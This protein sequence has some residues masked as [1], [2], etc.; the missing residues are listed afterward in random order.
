MSNKAKVIAVVGA[1]LSSSRLPRKHLLPLQGKPLITQVMKRLDAIAGLDKIILATTADAEN[2]DLARWAASAQR[3]IYRYEGDVNN[4]I[5]RIDAVVQRE[6]ADIIV[7]ICGDSPLIEP[8]TVANMITGLRNN[9]DTDM[10]ELIAPPNGQTWIHGGFDVYR[11]RFWDDMVAASSTPQE[12]EHVGSV[13]RTSYKVAPRDIYRSSDQAIFHSLYHRMSVDT[14]HDYLFM[15]QIYADWYAANPADSIVDLAWVMHQLAN[16]PKLRAINANVHQ[17]RVQDTHLNIRLFA[18]AGPGIGMGH[19]TRVCV[20]AL[21]LQE[22]LGAKP[23]IYVAGREIPNRLLNLLP[24]QWLDQL[25]EAESPLYRDADMLV[26][27]TKDTVNALP[28][29]QAQPQ[30]PFLMG[31]DPDHRQAARFDH[32]WM[33]SIFVPTHMQKTLGQKLSYGSDCFLLKP[34]FNQHVGAKKPGES[35]ILVLTGGADPLGLNTTLPDALLSALPKSCHITMVRG[36]YAQMPIQNLGGDAAKRFHILENQEN[37]PALLA[38][39]DYAITL[40]GVTFFECLQAQIPTVVFDPINAAIEPEWALVK[41]WMG[42]LAAQDQASA[43]SALAELISGNQHE[44]QK[45]IEIGTKLREG[46]RHF[47]ETVAKLCLQRE[48][49]HV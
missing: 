44:P 3:H 4:L 31:V 43:I 22:H 36:P 30:R 48:R 2:D 21:S 19:L 42:D 13:Y 1:R 26:F 33:P 41:S 47:A 18:Q 11:R 28:N 8:S 34:S 6:G 35:H 10:A 15:E 7:Y 40:Y 25:P 9:P 14:P 32:I 5:G 39:Y 12:Q 29:L 45:T 27:D 46:P 38:H 24:H 16:R 17:R 49:A 23:Q 20:A 37:L